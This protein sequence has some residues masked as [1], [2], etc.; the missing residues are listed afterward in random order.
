MAD[1]K[2]SQLPVASTPLAGTELVPVVQ[3]GA[4]EQT[5]VEAILTGTVPSGT[6]N[7]V[8]FLDGS[9][10][11]TSGSALTFD[12]VG[13][14]NQIASSGNAVSNLE[15]NST[16]NAVFRLRNTTTGALAGIFAN[17]SKELIFEANGASEQMR[18]NSTG[19]GIGT[20]SPGNKLHVQG[21]GDVARFTNGT[22]SAYFALDTAGFTLFTGAGQTGNGLYAKASD[23][24]VQLWTNSSVKATLDSSGNLGLG[25]TPSAWALPAFESQ[26]GLWAGRIEGNVTSN[27]YFNGGYNYIASGIEATRYRQLSGTHA[28]FISTD[29]TPTAGNAISFT[30]AMTL[31][32]SGNLGIGATSPLAKLDVV[33]GDGD[34]IQYRTGTR[35]VGIGQVASEAA[36]YWG[37]TTALTF[38]SG[39]ERMRLD[40]SGNLGLGVTP[41][42]WTS[43]K[44]L[45]V[46][47]T[48]GAL[49]SS[50]SSDLEITTNAYYNAGWL[51]QGAG[52]DSS[53]YRLNA[54]THAWFTAPSEPAGDPISFTQAMTLDASG[55]LL[56][57]TTSTIYRAQLGSQR[58][59]ATVP[60]L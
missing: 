3:G 8:L 48:G 15:A 40:S 2:I 41:S 7:G 17:N 34:G 50:S 16:N 44:A 23:N 53:R 30:Q 5:T 46:A 51:S 10:V 28:W 33:G 21:S 26:Y 9:K 36:V 18:L 27:A 42:A 1:A 38:F 45:Q 56:V 20:S 49:S 13:I 59:Q 12:G 58:Q 11:V 55:N 19:L 47:S 29:P 39:S 43:Y 60:K 57:G 24:S 54:G 6:A 32:G 35:T 22:N 52:V 25:V 4:T 14:L 37:S 31:D